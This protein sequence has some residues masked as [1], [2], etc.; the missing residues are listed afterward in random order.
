MKIAKLIIG[1][2]GFLP[3]TVAAV[4]AETVD[5]STVPAVVSE[6]KAEP[7]YAYQADRFRDPFVPL[8]GQ[9]AMDL[10]PIS[11]DEQIFK[12]N[13]ME[14]KGIIGSRTGRMALLRSAGG[15]IYVVKEGKILDS[16]RK[17]VNGFVGIVKE[18]SLV[19]I[20]PNNQVT[21]LKL[22]KESDSKTSAAR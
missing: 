14:L 8:A 2:I 6:V 10:P 4:C 3:V 22:T 18:K 1:F 5:G 7:E 17:P 13:E 11:Q 12:A 21:E 9:G 15:G 20:G 19:L 16:K